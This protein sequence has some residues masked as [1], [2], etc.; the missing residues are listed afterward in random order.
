M[1]TLLK[2]PWL[3]EC[4]EK[5]LSDVIEYKKREA[6]ARLEPKIK[7]EPDI[8][9]AAFSVP[10]HFER[11]GSRMRIEADISI[12]RMGAFVQVQEFI[13]RNTPV[14]ASV[15]DGYHVCTALFS[16]NAVDRHNELYE[17]RFTEMQGRVI[18]IKSF[19]IFARPTGSNASKLTL[20]VT[21]L[22]WPK[23]STSPTI[24][25]PEQLI[26][27][28]RTVKLLKSLDAILEHRTELPDD[29]GLQ[30]VAPSPDQETTLE[31]Q[32]STFSSG[33][34]LTSSDNN[35]TLNQS[36]VAPIQQMPIGRDRAGD[37]P[38]YGAPKAAQ[39]PGQIQQG[40]RANDACESSPDEIDDRARPPEKKPHQVVDMSDSPKAM[41]SNVNQELTRQTRNLS[42]T[43]VTMA[44]DAAPSWV[45]AGLLRSAVIVPKDQQ[46]IL[47]RKDSWYPPEPGRSFPSANVPLS[48]LKKF[49]DAAERRLREGDEDLVQV[50]NER[51][52]EQSDNGAS[53]DEP[54]EW[55]PSDDEREAEPQSSSSRSMSMHDSD[56][57][58]STVEWSP[59][60][61]EVN[62]EI[63][64]G[65]NDLPPD[66][67]LKS[68]ELPVANATKLSQNERP[69]ELNDRHDTNLLNYQ[70]NPKF[71]TD[72]HE[73]LANAAG[74]NEQ[75]ASNV[76]TT[77][78]PEQAR[79]SSSAKPFRRG[80]SSVEVPASQSEG[81]ELGYSPPQGVKL[82]PAP[83]VNPN[84]RCSTKPCHTRKGQTSR[85]NS[86]IA[87]RK[88]PL[89]PSPSDRSRVL[90]N[91]KNAN[92]RGSSFS[93]ERDTSSLTLRRQQYSALQNVRPHPRDAQLDD[94]GPPPDSSP[95]PQAHVTS[96]APESRK[97]LSRDGRSGNME[98]APVVI[99]RAPEIVDHAPARSIASSLPRS[100][101]D[102]SHALQGTDVFSKFKQAYPEYT[103]DRKHFHNLC[104]KISELHAQDKAQHRSLWDDYV[105]VHR[106]QYQAYVQ[107][108]N[109][110]GEDF[111]PYDRYYR[112]EVDDPQRRKGILTPSN[113]QLALQP[114]NNLTSGHG[115]PLSTSIPETVT[116]PSAPLGFPSDQ[117]MQ[118]P[119]VVEVPQRKDATRRAK[120]PETPK[121]KS[122]SDN[123][124]IAESSPEEFALALRRRHEVAKVA[125]LNDRDVKLVE[126][127]S[128]K[129]TIKK[130]RKASE[131]KARVNTVSNVD[132]RDKKRK[133]HALEDV[134]AEKPRK[135]V[136]Q[137]P[138]TKPQ[139]ISNAQGSKVRKPGKE[140][141]NEMW[142]DRNAPFKEFA[143]AYVNLKVFKGR[144]GT[145]DE[146]TG[147]VKPA[148][149]RIDTLGW[150]L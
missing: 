89:A 58:F 136:E 50:T 52:K 135:K 92:H 129:Q 16:S 138:P 133:S 74:S 9:D 124:P 147:I 97:T 105:L 109:E 108:M 17:R 115:T 78:H 65:A 94:T 31:R 111:T 128:K 51:E 106:M 2:A 144:Y 93:P 110:A 80:N 67:P 61:E 11:G 146:R 116:R 150:R 39:I 28:D 134:E 120:T 132:T 131:T 149:K 117:E 62:Q 32:S 14:R 42:E 112:D 122:V 99:E 102:S 55:D 75:R 142:K 57:P 139:A 5:S 100:V 12:A 6:V 86:K 46:A 85:S 8:Q 69:E 21:D 87:K 41:S 3:A 96:I 30:S 13:S 7:Q 23:S 79:H 73:V 66:T 104:R 25:R 125:V 68:I 45:Q 36:R 91:A 123:S 148:D 119:Q 127:P 24:G 48:L 113:L 19:E 27:R 84:L 60:Q 53:Q 4:V 121:V 35:T 101:S 77:Y 95:S 70:A 34:G 114:S 29:I 22:K 83:E 63:Y 143:R 88:S 71:N 15:S 54:F 82:P 26:F 145:V 130:A 33:L 1:A 141:A 49:N 76:S 137:A 107:M 40:Y 20:N 37:Q 59:T 81:S 140:S 47:D 118:S 43:N 103:G 18:Q 56:Q 64:D 126:T 44:V 72:P 38:A 10:M 90:K 98:G